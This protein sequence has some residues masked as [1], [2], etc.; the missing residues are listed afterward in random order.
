MTLDVRTV[1]LLL[2]VSAYLMTLLLVVGARG[3]RRDGITAWTVG[4]GLSALA[5]TLIAA[6]GHLPDIVAVAVADALLLA[7]PCFHVAALLEFGGRPVPR[8][9]LV[10]PPVVIFAAGTL[11]LDDYALLSVVVSLAYFAAMCSTAIVAW[12][13]GVSGGR[14]RWIIATLYAVGALA[15]L[16]R[17]VAIWLSPATQVGIFST[18]PIH[19]LTFTM[20]FAVTVGG[21]F[22]YLLLHRERSEADLRHLAMFDALTRLINRRAFMEFA[23]Q[24]LARAQRSGASIALLMLDIDNFKRVN[25]SYG[26]QAGDRVLADF[27]DRTRRHLRAGDIFGR[28]GGEE[29]CALLTFST[30]SDAAMIAERIRAATAY[31]PLGQIPATVTVSIGVVGCKNADGVSL[32]AV[33]AR[34]DKALYEA[35]RAGRNRVVVAPPFG[36]EPEASPNENLAPTSAAIALRTS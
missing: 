19:A 28:Y 16:A 30:A 8:W 14:T 5:W 6:R 25:D 9:L 34:S 17:G 11:L 24:E 33:I 12:Q 2:I 1:I 20:L 31:K 21:S 15:V 32:D 4:V 3:T 7:V 36:A 13:L 29:F 27:A 26:H 23:E 10:G 22:A 18:D 35:K